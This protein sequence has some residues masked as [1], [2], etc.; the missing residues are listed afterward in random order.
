[1][2]N[3]WTASKPSIISAFS[4]PTLVGNVNGSEAHDPWVIASGQALYFN[5]NGYIN[6]S[7]LGPSGFQTPQQIAELGQAASP[8]VT[9]DE[10]VIYFSADL[11]STDEDIFMARRSS[12]NDGFGMPI[13]V[14]ELN[15]STFDF[16]TWLSRDRCRMYYMSGYQVLLA[17][18][19]P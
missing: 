5:A 9:S 12:V 13:A 15:T 8:V 7:V 2:Y 17:E 3:I 10:L 16:P 19:S 14:T 4:A 18:R 6:R 11:G 1:L